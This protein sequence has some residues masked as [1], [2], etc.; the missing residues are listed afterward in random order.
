MQLITRLQSTRQSNISIHAQSEG[1]MEDKISGAIISSILGDSLGV[2]VEFEK[3]S[4]K[5]IIDNM[6]NSMYI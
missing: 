5:I 2:P 4:Y 6:Y 1:N 3:S